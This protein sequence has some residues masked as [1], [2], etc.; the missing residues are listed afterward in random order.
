MNSEGTKLLGSVFDHFMENGAFLFNATRLAPSEQEHCRLYYDFVQ[1]ASGAFIVDLGCGV[2]EVGAWFQHFDP[3]LS[4]LNVVNDPALIQQMEFWGRRCMNKSMDSTGLPDGVADNVMFNESIGYVP[5]EA[6][7]SEASRIL[8]PGGVLTIKDFSIID[9]KKKSI[10]LGDWDYSIRQP[11]DYIRIASAAGL[12]IQA[13][14]HPPVFTKHWYDIMDKSDVARESAMQ[15]NPAELP[16]C[17]VLYRFVK[18]ELN[19]RSA[20]CS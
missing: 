7:F 10:H 16:L 17:T 3:T 2:G 1:P 6:A 9:P 20:D 12:S 4:V 18:G 15:H 19:G 14:L 8:R 5:L 11:E 13:L